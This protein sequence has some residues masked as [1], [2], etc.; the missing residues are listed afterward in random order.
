MYWSLSEPATEHMLLILNREHLTFLSDPDTPDLGSWLWSNS[1]ARLLT[2]R[3]HFQFTLLEKY[4]RVPP[5]R[6]E[7]GAYRAELRRRRS[8]RFDKWADE[9]FDSTT[10]INNQANKLKLNK[11][12]DDEKGK[13]SLFLEREIAWLLVPFPLVWLVPTIS[14]KAKSPSWLTELDRYHSLT[15]ATSS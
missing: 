15:L 4:G 8:F 14:Q 9:S 6:Q 1:E 7:N 13:E 5:K 2:S 11:M 3:C 10:D 12:T